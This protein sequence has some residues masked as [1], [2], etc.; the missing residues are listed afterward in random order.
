ML[1]TI[2]FITSLLI[3]VNFLLLFFS[4]NKTTKKQGKKPVIIQLETTLEKQ[5]LAATGS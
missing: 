3:V 4:V 1:L 5:S 2:T